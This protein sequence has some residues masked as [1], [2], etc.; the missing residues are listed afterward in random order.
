MSEKDSCVSQSRTEYLAG[1]EPGMIYIS[2]SLRRDI[3]RIPTRYP[4][5]HNLFSRTDYLQSI[6]K[7]LKL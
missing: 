2:V 6:T 3:K 5:N 1:Y 7:N 4:E